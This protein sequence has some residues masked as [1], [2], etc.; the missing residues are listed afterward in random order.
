MKEIRKSGSAAASVASNRSNRP[1]TVIISAN[2]DDL[3]MDQLQKQLLEKSGECFDLQEQIEKLQETLKEKETEYEEVHRDLFTANLALGVE[4]DRKA[5]AQEE[6]EEKKQECEDLKKENQELKANMEKVQE[7]SGTIDE[8]L[9]SNT[10]AMEELK[11]KHDRALM[12]VVDELAEKESKLKELT[13]EVS[14]LKEK[15]EDWE[16]TYDH[17]KDEGAANVGVIAE[18]KQTLTVESAKNDELLIKLDALETERDVLQDE[19]ARLKKEN[20]FQKTLLQDKGNSNADGKD[21]AHVQEEVS[22]LIN[23]NADLS[24]QLKSIQESEKSLLSERERLVANAT[25]MSITL[26]DSRAK[27]DFLQ[28]QLEEYQNEALSNSQHGIG[29]YSDHGASI[30]ASTTNPRHST[31]SGLQ[32]FTGSLRGSSARNIAPGASIGTAI[33][34]ES[35]RSLGGASRRG[36]RFRSFL[37]NRINRQDENAGSVIEE[38]AAAAATSDSNEKSTEKALRIA[39]V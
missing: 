19:V 17:L 15:V 1:P 34:D 9:A 25:H 26:A 3:T 4:V 39:S 18:L 23:E 22:K 14:A 20:A 30:T 28:M 38:A 10:A 5:T 12:Q 31:K 7:R 8:E 36:D 29:R 33:G 24:K 32:R 37:H 27:V 21:T 13:L 35:E 2:T 16:V 6:L 11:S